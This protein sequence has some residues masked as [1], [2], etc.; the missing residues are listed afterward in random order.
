MNSSTLAKDGW[1][2]QDHAWAETDRRSPDS[3]VD[4][5]G[6]DRKD[7][8]TVDVFKQVPK[9]M[10]RLSRLAEQLFA[11]RQDFVYGL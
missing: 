3:A 1:R 8:L 4:K 9:P 10:T 2:R 11:A 5:L 6:A 7:W